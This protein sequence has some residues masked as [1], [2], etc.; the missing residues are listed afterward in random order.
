MNEPE[1]FSFMSYWEGKWPLKRKTSFLLQGGSIN[2]IKAHR[3]AYEVI[4][5]IQPTSQVGIATNNSY[6]EAYK[7][8]PI[9][10]VIKNLIESLDHFYF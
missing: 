4:K 8:D 2:L 10:F 7:N 3:K 9:A 5:K 6:Y 1:L